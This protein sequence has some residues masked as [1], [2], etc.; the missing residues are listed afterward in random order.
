MHEIDLPAQ[1][2]AVRNVL[3][4]RG[5]RSAL[6]LLN[7]RTPYRYTAIHKLIG[8]TMEAVHVFDRNAE[9]RS[10]LKAVPLD[11]SFCQFAIR[12]GEFTV[13]HASQD[14]SLVSP[15]D[16]LVES[17]HGQLLRREDGSPWGTFIHFD[18]EP[19]SIAQ[20]EVAFLQDVIPFFL[21]Y[22]D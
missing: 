2:A 15:Y 17:Y 1:A 4:N 22:L 9:Y 19:R 6:A 18:V 5:I 10:W 3:A 11:R 14:P 12:E 16:G 21:D 13:H 20:E 8:E 7:D